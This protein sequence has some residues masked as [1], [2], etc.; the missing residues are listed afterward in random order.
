VT[1]AA[2]AVAQV[3]NALRTA[4]VLL[5]IQFALTTNAASVQRILNANR[6]SVIPTVGDAF[7][8]KVTRIASKVI[9]ILSEE[10][11]TTAGVWSVI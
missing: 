1:V 5:F 11:T 7:N 6:A 3:A 9:V 4:I 10:A 8:A 2:Q